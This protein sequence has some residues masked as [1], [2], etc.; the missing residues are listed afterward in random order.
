MLGVTYVT[1]QWDRVPGATGYDIF[2]NGVKVSSTKTALTAKLGASMGTT[3]Y[4]IRPRGV[5]HPGF[6]LEL[7]EWVVT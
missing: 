4:E 1:V 5:V 6:F 2:K 7:K 3:K